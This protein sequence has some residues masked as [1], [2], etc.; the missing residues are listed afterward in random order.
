[1]IYRKY[2]KRIFD[3]LLSAIAIVILLPVYLVLAILVYNSMG[4]PILYCQKRIGKGEKVFVLKK[5]RSMTSEKDAYG[6]LRS[7]HERLTKVGIALRSSSLDEIPELFSIIKGDMSFIGPRPLPEYYGPYFY[8]TERIRHTVN[9]G[10]IPPD[11]LS[12]EILP[13]WEVQ[14]FYD[15]YYVNNISF[16][17]DLK[18]ILATLTILI[19][20]IKNNYG[21]ENRLHLS[22]YRKSMKL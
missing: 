12:G 8:E 6:N 19:K 7:E 18:I 17:L 13:K 16:F 20:R 11:C 21:A 5:F 22:E 2:V 1:L 9:G 4:R 3:I 15:I 14:F 10:L